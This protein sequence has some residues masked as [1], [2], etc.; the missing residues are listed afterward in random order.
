MKNPIE[1]RVHVKS[2]LAQVWNAWTDPKHIVN[3]NFATQTWHCPLA[4][5]KL[6]AGGSFSY[7]MAAKDGSMSF[8]FKGVFELVEEKNRLTFTLDDGRAVEVSFQQEDEDVLLIERFEPDQL[9][10][11]VLQ[12]A[13]WQAIV[14]NFKAYVEG[15]SVHEK[16]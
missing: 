9:N 7:T 5:L 2:N 6:H 1:V 11:V 15:L 16:I 3:W 4:Q 12:K 13:G 10:D 14:D 8:D